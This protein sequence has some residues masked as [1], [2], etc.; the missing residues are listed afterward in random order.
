MTEPTAH[1][2]ARLA[3]RVPVAPVNDIAQALDN[4]FTAHM[5]AEVDHPDRKAMRVLKSPIRLDQRHLPARAAPLLGDDTDAILGEL[6][7]DATAIEKLRAGG[8]V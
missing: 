8:V 6:G 2:V 3:G 1:W 5:I 7:Y 4:P